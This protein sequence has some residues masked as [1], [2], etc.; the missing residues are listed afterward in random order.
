MTAEHW[1]ITVDDQHLETMDEVVSELEASGLVID[2]VLRS[3]GQI[4]GHTKEAAGAANLAGVPGVAS[5][6]NS[7]RHQIAPPDAEVQ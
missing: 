5:A 4:T 2:K 1:I 3:L 6:D 7:R